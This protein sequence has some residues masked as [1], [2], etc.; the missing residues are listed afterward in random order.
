M[1]HAVRNC[2]VR[3]LLYIRPV[4]RLEKEMVEVHF[5]ELLRSRAGLRKHELE[6]T[7]SSLH[8]WSSGLR[9]D[10]DPV[11]RRRGVARPVRLD[12]NGKPALV[13]SVDQRL[14]EL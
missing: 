14:V 10:A 1:Q 4:H 6:L 8:E 12:S 2:V 7:A 9:A 5:A 11:N 3:I 13:K